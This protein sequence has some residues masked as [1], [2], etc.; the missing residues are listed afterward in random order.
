M[1]DLPR[2]TSTSAVLAGLIA[3]VVAYTGPLVLVIQAAERAGLDR[4]VVSS[5]IWALTAGSGVISLPLS[6]WYRQPIVAAWSIAGSAL[7]VTELG[8]FRIEEAVGAYLVAGIATA[9]LGWSGLFGRMMSLVPAPVVM[10]MLA[11]VLLRFG[12]GLFTALPGR[13]LIVLAM[14]AAFL[15]LRWR[16]VRA[17]TVGALAAGVLA[18]VLSNDVRL[19]SVSLEIATPVWIWPVFSVGALLSLA[20]PLFVLAIA[21]QDAPGLAVLRAAGYTTPPDGPI[22]L[23]GLASIVTA[24]FAG[25]GLNLAALMAA[26][27]SSPEAHPDSD[28]RY[29]AGVAAGVWFI[30]FGMLGATAVSL[31]AALP[32][33]LIAAVAGLAMVPSLVSSLTGATAQDEHR[34]GALFALLV[35]ASDVTLLGIGAPFWALLLGVATS[36][37]LGLAR[38]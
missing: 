28:R 20:L 7:L 9:V 5:W 13:P 11:G 35:A 31:F 17:P 21:S 23:T 24:P 26:I 34:E 6:L 10:G 3:V 4:S 22:L 37:T 36:K 8:R 30:L 38:R 16:R 25:H 1:R 2:V 33:E 15:V 19:A 27:C 14:L 12:I 29:A 32:R 18:A